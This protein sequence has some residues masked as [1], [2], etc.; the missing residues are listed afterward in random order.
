M[1]ISCADSRVDPCKILGLDLGE[2]FVVRN[3]ANLVPAYTAVCNL[4]LYI[5]YS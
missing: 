4:P 3:V 1:I 5:F 2:A